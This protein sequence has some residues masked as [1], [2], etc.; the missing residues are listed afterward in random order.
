MKRWISMMLVLTGASLAPAADLWTGGG[1]DNNWSTASNWDDNLV[2]AFPA[3]LH[4]GG[5]ARLTPGNDFSSRTV[6]GIT[7]DGGAGAFV[8]GG[9]AITL[10]GDIVNSSAKTQ[11]INFDMTLDAVRTV[12]AASADIYLGGDLS[13]EGG[14]VLTG[15]SS[16][17]LHLSGNNTFSGPVTVNDG[18]VKTYSDTSF[19]TGTVIFNGGRW[20]GAGDAVLA[21][22]IVFNE[23][24]NGNALSRTTEFTGRF[25]GTGSLYINGFDSGVVTLSGDNSGWSGNWEFNGRIR[26]QLNHIR[27]LGKGDTVT[28]DTAVK[29]GASQGVLESLVELTGANALMQNINLG[30]DTGLSG[31]TSTMSTTA[32]MALAGTVRG[33]ATARLVKAG[34]ATLTLTRANTYSGGTDVRA[35]VLVGNAG[36]AFG[37]GGIRVA[38]GATLILRGDSA[39]DLI[40][41]AAELTLGKSA[42]LALD[43][44]GIET[45][46]A[47]SL[48]GGSSP[49]PGGT[50]DAAMLS[51]IGAGSCR[52]TGRLRVAGG[53]IQIEPADHPGLSGGNAAEEG[54]KAVAGSSRDA[55]HSV[56]PQKTIPRFLGAG[57]LPMTVGPP[58]AALDGDQTTMWWS[59][60]DPEQTFTVWFDAPWPVRSVE[61]EWGKQYPSRY[62]IQATA[63]GRGWE[64]VF[65]VDQFKNPAT[66]KGKVAWVSD[67]LEEPFVAKAIRIRTLAG[68][69]DGVQ[70]VD[71]F[72]NGSLPFSFVV[73]PPDARFRDPAARIDERVTDLLGRMNFR[74]KLRLTSGMNYFF[75]PG[76][77]RFGF[78]PVMMANAS[79]GV[80]FQRSIP[81]EYQT[82]DQSTAFPLLAAVGATWDPELAFEMGEAIGR[83]CRAAGASILLGPGVNIHRTSTCGRNFEYFSEDPLLTSALAVRNI[84]GLQREGALAVI[85]HY[86]VNNNEFL[87]GTCDVQVGERALNE[88]FLPAFREAVDQAGLKVVMSS[89][90]W[91]NGEKCGESPA[92]LKEILRGQL[93]F[94]GF[95]M[96]D[97]G[98]T[99]DDNRRILESGQNLIMPQM[100]LFGQAMRAA[101]AEHPEKTEAE[102]DAMIAPTLR[103]LLETGIW[104]RFPSEGE[105]DFAAQDAL[106]LRI[107]QSAV[108]LLKNEQVLPLKKTDQILVVGESAAVKRASSGGGSGSV[109]GYHQVD[110]LSGLE[111][112]FESVTY[113]ETP[114]VAEIQSA[115]CVVFFFSMRDRE[116]TDRPFELPE[117]T[118]QQIDLLTEN[119]EKVIVV[120]SSGTA[121]RAPWLNDIEGLVH[122]YFLGQAHGTAL[123]GVLSGAV[124][125]SGKLPF[126]MEQ[127]FRDSPAFGYNVFNGKNEWG[128]TFRGAPP[129]GYDL[130]YGEGV[131][132]GYR[133]YE[134][135]SKPIHFP[136]GFGLSYTSFEING[137]DLS[138][139]TVSKEKPLKVNVTVKN[140]GDAAGAEVVQLYVHDQKSSVP[141][142]FRELRGFQKVWLMPGEEKVVEF[143]LVWEDFAFWDVETHGWKIER[144]AFDML[145]G[146]SSRNVQCSA[147]VF[148]SGGKE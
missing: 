42:G 81:W 127:D 26:L 75:I 10:G 148:Y 125:P 67:Q 11:T 37:T 95:V 137:L 70:I 124:N 20:S 87:R 36:G 133:W 15:N 2:P 52:G 93:G 21:N 115:D 6:T 116:G 130:P 24:M 140:S 129:A 25:T 65:R 60:A 108:T 94:Q 13:G 114:T 63:D 29:A 40:D 34:P 141:R 78:Y 107:A 132:V 79:S 12:N 22:D 58:S 4:F 33:A 77:E 86:A 9:N 109:T 84:Q 90:N 131:F 88:I 83:E 97:W 73:P 143:S 111:A 92:L 56:P 30:D 54:T 53:A 16:Q 55:A 118:D 102:L 59:D 128:G 89:Y 57:T 44:I 112:A 76:I 7:F 101:Y 69:M 17:N 145:I 71:L 142:P 50:Y 120:A 41:D 28:F 100:K 51:E 99:S 39:G 74:E 136:F 19:G 105:V 134:A 147:E 139:K 3:G 135:N 91:M 68:E 119:N 48:D 62:E 66:T 80:K 35:G 104:E 117:K 27:A 85:K 110:Y 64:T 96:S 38:D 5:T 8:L 113:S 1:A 121:F 103:V 122:C 14:L 61:I 123:A 32:D 18:V 31:N 72:V 46:G 146:N 82:I 47:I 43:F 45:V 126:T 106:A 49:L 144:G 98:G 138:C 23:G